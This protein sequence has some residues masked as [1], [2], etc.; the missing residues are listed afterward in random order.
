MHLKIINTISGLQFFQLLRFGTLLLISIFFTKSNVTTEAIGNYEFFL[1]VSTLACSFWINGLIQ[2]FLPLFRNNYS[3]TQTGCRSPEFFNVFVLLSIFS[4]LVV[5]VLFFFRFSILGLL[6]K[7]GTIPYFNFLLVYIFF[8]SPAFLVEYIYLLKD[9]AGWIIKYGLITFSVQFILVVVPVFLGMGMEISIMGLVAVSVIR[10]GWL[11]VLLKRYAQFSLSKG[12]IKEHL[13][14]A[15][16]LI[17]SSL[18]GA[19][20]QY[21]DG[22]L[23]LNEF[24]T[25]TFAVFRYGAKEFPL[26]LMM[27]N[28]LNTAMIPVFS[29]KKKL[30]ET[31]MSLRNKTARLMHLLFPVTII[32]MIFSNWLYPRVFNENFTASAGIFNIYLLLVI[33]RLVFPHTILIGLKKTKIIMYASMAELVVNVILSIVFIRFWGIEGVAFATFIAYAIQKIVWVGYN[34]IVLGISP[35]EYIP[36][37]VWGIYSFLTLVVFYVVY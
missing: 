20:A 10:Y 15:L 34:K 27:A 37:L 6:G 3:F 8:S 26:V 33:S 24:D 29:A 30:S 16:P 17:V 13:H 5:V 7:S 28:A 36:I 23:V 18:L 31:L 25:A 4:F 32:F 22:F 12:F 21:V 2:S 14:L 1:F 19:S 9:K 11:V 35:G